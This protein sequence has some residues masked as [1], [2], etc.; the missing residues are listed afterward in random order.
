MYEQDNRPGQAA[1]WLSR[2][3]KEHPDLIMSGGIDKRVLTEDTKI[4]DEYLE[5][6]KPVSAW[7]LGANNGLFS[8]SASDRNIPT[9]ACDIDPAAVEAN[10][11]ACVDQ[12]ESN[13]L[14][15][16]MDF[17]NPSPGLGW[18]GDERLSLVHR[19][20][21]DTVMALALIHHLAISDRREP[22][23]QRHA[24]QKTWIRQTA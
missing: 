14:P 2:V 18:R 8:R 7:D 13:I 1:R 15:L 4:I 3:R 19:G 5:R 9:V 21:A 20:P 16:V 12:K 24:V 17:T 11:K 22:V 23:F 10:Y 6:I